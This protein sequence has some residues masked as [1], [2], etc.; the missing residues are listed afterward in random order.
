[1]TF[2]RAVQ[3]EQLYRYE[4]TAALNAVVRACQDIV[5]DHSHRGFWAPRTSTEPTPSHRELIEAARRDVLNR[6]QTVIHC[7][8]TVAYTIE[9]DRR[10]RPSRT[11]E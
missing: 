6:L 5:T 10:R 11:T 4:I 1:M 3:T 7:A 9:H 2:D 8:E